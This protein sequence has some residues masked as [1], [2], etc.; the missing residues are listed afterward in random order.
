MKQ[1]YPKDLQKAIDFHG[2]FCPGLAIGYR[3][4]KAAMEKL[5][6]ERAEDEEL[7]AIVETDACGIDAVQSLLGCTMGKG[8]LIYKDYGKQVYTIVSRK[9][10]KAVRVAM[11]A[12]VFPQ[13]PAQEK[14]RSAVFSGQA[15]EEERKEFQKMQQ[16]K[17][18]QLLTTDT[19]TLF[20]VEFVEMPLPQP[21]KIFRSVTCD[22]CGEPVMEPRARIKDGKIA[23]LPCNEEYSR[24]W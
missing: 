23:C 20:K 14:L 6:V 19:D 3:A 4:A 24:G 16:A 9:Q 12:N 10:N 8:N 17:I 13:S 11:R 5:Q 7:V 15:T 2:H 22:Y 18:K 1:D 21:A